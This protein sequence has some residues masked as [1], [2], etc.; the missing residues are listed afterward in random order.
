MASTFKLLF[1]F[2]YAGSDGYGALRVLVVVLNYMK[3]LISVNLW[4]KFCCILTKKNSQLFLRR[5]L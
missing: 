5:S 1:C 3:C 2:C 4:S